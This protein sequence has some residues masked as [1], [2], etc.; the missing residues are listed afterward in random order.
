MN[1]ECNNTS[2]L[3]NPS[4]NRTQRDIFK[5]FGFYSV[6][7]LSESDRKPPEFIVDDMIP[8]GLSFLSGAPKTRKSFMALQLAIAVATGNMFLGKSTIPCDVAYFDLEGS[9]S[10]VFNRTSRMTISIPQNVYVTNSIGEKLASGKLVNLLRDLHKQYPQIRLIIIDT[11]SRAKGR[12][13]MTGG[14]NAYDADVELLEPIQRMAINE[15]IAVL[16]VHHY[17]KGASFMSDSFEQISGTMGISGSADCVLNLTTDGKRFDG[18]AV[19]EYTPRDAIGG[20]LPLVF[21][22]SHL[23]WV[24]ESITPP[25]LKCNPLFKWII[26]NDDIKS[27]KDAKFF[28]YEDVYSQAYHSWTEEPGNIIRKQIETYQD[29]LFRDYRIA[30]QVG[31]QSNGK[32]GIRVIKTQ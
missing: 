2:K 32:R 19:L 13:K 7:T 6:P 27:K 8:I 9:K 28:P 25:D 12:V 4:D 5:E 20:E 23:E 26:E 18:K 29:D 21:D 15:N 1:V 30:V 3:L 31:S 22:N 10:R 14:A 11:F 17:K 24:A 16:F